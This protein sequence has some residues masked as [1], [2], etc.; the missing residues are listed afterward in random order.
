M[1]KLR[2]ML[3]MLKRMSRR[4]ASR[5]NQRLISRKKHVMMPKV[6]TTGKKRLLAIVEGY[7]K[8]IRQ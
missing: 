8:D 1:R 2:I 4:K 3:R 7:L 6:Y 5:S